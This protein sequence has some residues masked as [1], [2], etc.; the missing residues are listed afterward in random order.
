MRL[1]PK[2]G[3]ELPVDALFC[4]MCGEEITPHCINCGVA[5]PGEASYCPMCGIPIVEDIL[6][7]SSKMKAPENLTAKQQPQKSTINNDDFLDTKPHHWIRTW[8]RLLDIYVFFNVS[9]LIIFL[10]ALLFASPTK[11]FVDPFDK[12]PFLVYNVFLIWTAFI[13]ESIVL[14]LFQTTP[15]KK[16][17]N[18]KLVPQSTNR[19]TFNLAFNRSFK[20]LRDG[21]WF[22]LPFLYLIPIQ[23]NLMKLIK[24]GSMPWDR[25]LN[26]LVLHKNVSIFRWLIYMAIMGALLFTTLSN[27]AM[28]N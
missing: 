26:I 1:C 22:G 24:K 11:K 6:P 10:F 3:K 21:F 15:G 27:L 9:Y 13:I 18:I 5:L 25:E 28:L 7:K 2:C 16:L 20:V 14:M 8:A 23:M 17:L 19:F 12:I 4:S